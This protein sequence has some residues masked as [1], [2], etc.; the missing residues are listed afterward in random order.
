MAGREADPL[1][2]T[3]PAPVSCQFCNALAVEVQD[4]YV[5]ITA[6]SDLYIAEYGNAERRIVAR[7][8]MP[9][10]VARA[11]AKELRKGLGR[12]EH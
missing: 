1:Q 7:I 6:F 12:G 9:D 2:I 5:R 8:A 4:G 10:V 3:E 11:L